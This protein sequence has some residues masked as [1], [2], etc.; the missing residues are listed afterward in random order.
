MQNT[1]ILEKKQTM[2]PAAEK[3]YGKL[4]MFEV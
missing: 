2:V 1:V 4:P 3:L